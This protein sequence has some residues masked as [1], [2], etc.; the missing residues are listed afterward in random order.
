MFPFSC[1]SPL[2]VSRKG[3]SADDLLH[4]Y[5][6]P[7]LFVVLFLYGMSSSILSYIISMFAKSPLAAWS[8]CASGQVVFCLA[9]FS[10][11]LGVQSNVGIADL[12]PTLDKIHFTL[13]L[14]SPVANVMRSL[15]VALNQ[16][17]LLCGD[18]SNPG[19]ILLYGGPILYLILQIFFFFGILLWWDSGVSPMALLTRKRT[20]PTFDMGE[21]SK[22]NPRDLADEVARVKSSAAGLRVLHLSKS[23][24]KTEA[25]D[26]VTFGVQRGEV[27]AL[28]GP[29]GAGK[30]TSHRC[31]HRCHTH[32]KS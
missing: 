14:V 30:S 8:L 18:A 15:F 25:V 3:I 31:Y 26:D 22:S 6:L 21:A 27:F 20:K 24:G 19:G 28:L 16:F 32:R 5:H 9:Y 4:R 11:Y 13:G 29:N 1:Y 12:I 2:E 7:Y 17:T 23:F 10:A